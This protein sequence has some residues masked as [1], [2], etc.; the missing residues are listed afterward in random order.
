V[1]GL[2]V[3][4]GTGATGTFAFW[5]DEATVT[6]TGFTAGSIDLRVNTLD[7]VTGY[8][9]LSLT[10]MVPGNSTAGVLTI[11]NNGTAPLKYSAVSSASNAD[12]KALG[13][14]LTVKV[15]ADSSVTS[16]SPTATCAGAALPGTGSGLNGPLIATGRLLAAG[17]SETICVQ[18]KLPDTAASTLQGA[19]T[20]VGFTF[21]GT[22][23]VS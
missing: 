11:R 7:N 4:L 8:T 5:T 18:V 10:G 23:D 1:L 21:T 19:T 6:G 12:G 16:A 9:T 15:T 2:G 3:L 13:A 17:T 14:A 20:N 22:S